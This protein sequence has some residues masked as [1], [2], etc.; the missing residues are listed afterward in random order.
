MNKQGKYGP[1]IQPKVED[2]EERHPR[3]GNNNGPEERMAPT[4]T[5]CSA[6]HE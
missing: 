5:V 3:T 2:Y 4:E 6:T 1:I